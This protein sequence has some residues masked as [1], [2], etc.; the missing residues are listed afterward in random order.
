MQVAVVFEQRRGRLAPLFAPVAARRAEP[1]RGGGRARFVRPPVSDQALRARLGPLRRRATRQVG[2]RLGR[3]PLRSRS[4]PA[5]PRSRT[6][7][8]SLERHRRARDLPGRGRRRLRSLRGRGDRPRGGAAPPAHLARRRRSRP[9]ARPAPSSRPCW[10]SRPG[11]AGTCCASARSGRPPSPAGA[12]AVGAGRRAGWRRLRRVALAV[13]RDVGGQLDRHERVELLR[14][15]RRRPARCSAASPSTP[16]RNAGRNP[17]AIYREPMTHGRLLRRAHGHHAL[18]PLRLRRALRRLRGHHRLGQP[19]RRATCA[20]TPVHIEAV[21]T[22]I[23]ERV[24]WDQGTISHEPQLWARPPTSGPEPRSRP[25]DVDVALL[26]DGF[27]FNCLSWIE[28]AGLLRHGRGVATSSAT[29]RA[30]PSTA[31]CPLNTHGG[32]L[33]AGRS[34]AS[35]SWQR[36]SGS[37]EARRGSARSPTRS[38]AC[39]STGGGVPSSAWLLRSTELMVTTG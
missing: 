12:R 5:W 10:P 19:R 2:R 11:C 16:A 3:D 13:R 39:V 33:S 36:P 1:A 32:Q 35:A 15:L 26:Y 22:Q 18:R 21:G 20:A 27:S 14:P 17:D 28:V 29:A 37:C 31:S 30:S 34:T 38:V 9:R 7:G 24:S 25:D 4:R 23:I 8:S 6:P